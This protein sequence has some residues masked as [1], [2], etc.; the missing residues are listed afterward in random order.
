MYIKSSELN[1]Y[2]CICIYIHNYSVLFSKHNTKLNCVISL[3]V[4]EVSFYYYY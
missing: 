2:I 1:I 4:N 3:T